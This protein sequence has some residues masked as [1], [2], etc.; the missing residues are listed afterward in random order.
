[1]AFRKKQNDCFF[2]TP[3]FLILIFILFCK[4]GLCKTNILFE[5]YSVLKSVKTPQELIF[6]FFPSRYSAKIK[7]S[8]DIAEEMISNLKSLGLKE[9]IFNETF[10]KKNLFEISVLNDDYSLETKE[11]L[12]AILNPVQMTDI[13]LSSILKLKEKEKFNEIVKDTKAEMNFIHD[14]SKTYIIIILVPKGKYISYSYEDMG[15]YIRES[16]IDSLTC[17]IDSSTLCICEL[18]MRKIGR[19]FVSD[20]INKPPLDTVLFNYFFEYSQ[21]DNA[22]LPFCLTMH[23]NNSIRLK[24]SATYK[25]KD[26]IILFDKREI[27][28]L[29]Q[30]S[31]SLGFSCLKII[32][33]EYDL[34]KQK[35]QA[36]PVFS[37]KYTK[38]LEKSAELSRKA[39]N[40]LKKGNIDAALEILKKIASDYPN[41]P[42][43]IEAKK[44]ISSLPDKK[45]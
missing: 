37:H 21:Y 38:E 7:F 24:I 27:C 17:K 30:D 18:F 23:I 36:K 8:G 34:N 19:T 2:L 12:S 28:Y 25:K 16:W 15:A 13:V 43:A 20:R 3:L 42:Q 39:M 14:S 41:T 10:D 29:R 32:Y 22:L 4:N 35:E 33:Q 9:P 45:Y 44:L 40:Y 11:M 5:P 6:P 26:N 1:M 31:K